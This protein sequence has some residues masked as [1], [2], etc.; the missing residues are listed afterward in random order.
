M[1]AITPATSSSAQGIFGVVNFAAIGDGDTW[2]G[3]KG[4]KGSWAQVTA[5][6]T[7]NTS[8]GINFTYDSSTGIFTFYPGVVAL[9]GSLFYIK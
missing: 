4:L 6:P 5:D 3:P 1:A 2:T 7:T 8:A 9:T